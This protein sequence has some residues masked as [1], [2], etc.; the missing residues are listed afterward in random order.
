MIRVELHGLEVYGYH[1]VEDYERRD[2]Q[3]FLFDIELELAAEPVADR[4]GDTIDYRLVA[5]TIKAVSDAAPL[6]L[7]ESLA[8]RSAD[9]LLAAFPAAAVVRVRARKPEVR[10]D[11]F[12]L[13]WSAAAVERRRH[14]G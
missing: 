5:D 1:G 11:G 9:A 13:D 4:I 12:R 2:G 8:A 7:L 6:Q 10:L 3:R 14:Q